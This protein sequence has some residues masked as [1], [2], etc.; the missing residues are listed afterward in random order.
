MSNYYDYSCNSCGFI[1]KDVEQSIMDPP[2]KKCPKCSHMTLERLISGGCHAY[3]DPGVTTLGKLAEVNTK[4]M[5]KEIQQKKTE[6][7][8]EAI[9]KAGFKPRDRQKQ[10]IQ[11]MTP[12]QQKRWI[13]E[14]D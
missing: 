14:G 7:G 6:E 11:N 13:M 4:K 10:K 3:T 12:D 5:G 2:K 1:W 9:A 8:K